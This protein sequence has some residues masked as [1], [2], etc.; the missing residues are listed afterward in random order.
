MSGDLI[1][2][3]MENW[4]D[5]WRRNQF[6]C[7]ELA[8]RY[9]EMKILFVGLPRN[10][11]HGIRHGNLREFRQRATYRAKGFPN[12]TITH[13]LKLF[14]NSVAAGR[15]GNERMFRRHVR[16]VAASLGMDRPVLWLN[17]HSAV[18][19]VGK[20]DESAVIYDITDDWTTLTQS[21]RLTQLIR[22]QDARL[23]RSADAV[24]VCSDRLYD[25]KRPLVS[26]GRLHLIPNGVHVEHYRG[27]LDKSAPGG[28]MAREWPRPVM[29]YTGTIHPDRIDVQ[30]IRQ[31]AGASG[32]GSVV[33]V[34]PNHLRAP[35]LESLRL[36]NIF[37][38]G[39]VP[40]EEIPEVMR[41][42]DVCIV[43]HKVTPFTESLNPIKLWEYL[44]A[45]KPIVSTDIAG[46]RDFPH[47]VSIARTN[48]Q[49]IAAAL[50]AL[51][52]DHA[53]ATAR[54]AEARKH[55]WESRVDLIEQVL[56]KCVAANH[57][58]S[59]VG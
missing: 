38:T 4:D 57:E 31:L 35:D 52:E 3:S 44:A 18:H 33:L 30:L 22:R 17:P 34:G 49:F 51:D 8:A 25:L 7:A 2:V 9:A 1:F 48:E 20:M 53:I 59:H 39:P 50:A 55:S 19:M 56:H 37:M 5:I 11:S 13:P 27:V 29:G 42:F 58:V 41:A 23:C 12:I 32:V 24:I 36:P 16:A 10:V 26:T 47:L 40:Y 6:V 54:I 28:P 45:G 21:P 14:P 46:F 43:P 15:A